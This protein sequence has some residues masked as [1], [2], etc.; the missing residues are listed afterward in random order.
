MADLYCKKANKYQ[1]LVT[2]LCQTNDRPTTEGNTSSL[3]LVPNFQGLVQKWEF[4]IPHRG[5]LARE[6]FQDTIYGA[7]WAPVCR[8]EWVCGVLLTNRIYNGT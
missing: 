7:G 8:R 4:V 3:S 2:C 6:G 1:P 5:K